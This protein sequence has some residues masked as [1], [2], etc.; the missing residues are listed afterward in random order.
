[1]LHL[2]RQ[3]L[4]LL[5]QAS[6]FLIK[7][8]LHVFFQDLCLSLPFISVLGLLL[9]PLDLFTIL[10]IPFLEVF[11]TNPAVLERKLQIA[12]LL[13]QVFDLTVLAPFLVVSTL[14]FKFKSILHV[15]RMGG[16]FFEQ[17]AYLLRHCSELLL[18]SYHVLLLPFD[19][20]LNSG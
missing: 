13:D 15:N 4:D 7:T 11:G 9:D 10:A 1:M 18:Q 3:L 20:C 2:C 8:A 6:A 16:L 5:P 17:L 14:S 19:R 12:H